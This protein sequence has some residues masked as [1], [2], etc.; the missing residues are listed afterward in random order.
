VARSPLSGVVGGGICLCSTSL[1]GSTVGVVRT[2]CRVKFWMDTKVAR[3]W[4]G[5]GKLGAQRSFR[6]TRVVQGMPLLVA[7]IQ[8]EVAQ[9]LEKKTTRSARSRTS[10]MIS[11]ISP[12]PQRLWEHQS[13]PTRVSFTESLE[14]WTQGFA[15]VW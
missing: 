10:H 4:M 7:T 1:C 2:G 6:R 13:D 9:R 8:R 3:H 14:S 5:V 15:N 11:V 12:W